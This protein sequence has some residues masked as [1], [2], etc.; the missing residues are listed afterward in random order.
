MTL[1]CIYFVCR[2]DVIVFLCYVNCLFVF[3]WKLFKLEL[4]V[5]TMGKKELHGVLYFWI[6]QLLQ[7]LKEVLCEEARFRKV[8]NGLLVSTS[9]IVWSSCSCHVTNIAVSF[10]VILMLLLTKWYYMLL[11]HFALNSSQMQ[12]HDEALLALLLVFLE[13]PHAWPVPS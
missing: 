4:N 3:I 7:F 9:F 10:Q 1:F 6:C 5:E 13:I 8:L 2:E 11:D 12:M